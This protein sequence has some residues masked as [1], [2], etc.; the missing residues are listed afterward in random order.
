MAITAAMEAESVASRPMEILHAQGLTCVKFA[1]ERGRLLLRAIQVRVDFIR[2][3]L[4]AN[5]RR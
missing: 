1:P 3:H 5:Q 2:S 4:H